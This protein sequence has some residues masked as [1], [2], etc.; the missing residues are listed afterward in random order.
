[1]PSTTPDQPPVWTTVEFAFE[2]ANADEVAS[3]LSAVLS[4]EGGWYTNFTLD[5]EVFV[6]FA[7]RIIRYRRGDPAGR[8]E[9][10]AFGRYVGVPSRQLGWDE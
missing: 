5:N 6:I 3:E 1:M 9:A 4:T 10:A 7:N 8:A 2:E